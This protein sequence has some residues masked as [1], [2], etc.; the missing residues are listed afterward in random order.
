MLKKWLKKLE[1]KIFNMYKHI[2]TTKSYS[3]I[4]RFISSYKKI[5]MDLYYD[6]WLYN[7]EMIINNYIQTSDKLFDLIKVK[8]KEEFEKEKNYM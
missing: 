1:I 7:E 4:E 5:F 3:K 6:T 8:I 2:Y